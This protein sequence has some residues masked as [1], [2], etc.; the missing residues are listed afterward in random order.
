MEQG[1]YETVKEWFAKNHGI[2]THGFIEWKQRTPAP[3]P[4]IRGYYYWN[5]G[6]GTVGPIGKNASAAF[7]GWSDVDHAISDF[8]DTSVL[9]GTKY[10]TVGGG[11][12][13]GQITAEALKKYAISGQK[14]KNAGYEAV[15][16]DIEEIKGSH[17]MMIPLFAQAF[18]AIKKAGLGVGVTVSKCAPYQADT[19]ID[20]VEFIKAWVKDENIDFMS[21]QLYTTGYEPEPLFI[22]TS[23]CKEAGCTWDLWRNAVPKVVP[24]IVGQEQYETVKEWFAKNYDIETAGFFEW[25]QRAPAAEVKLTSSANRRKISS[26]TQ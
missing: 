4:E 13:S 6:S 10:L 2:E 5:W 18:A 25:K 24:S 15:M 22:E 14:I 16:F 17:T 23:F 3:T 7:T 11:D 1:Q 21:P 8:P 26:F 12:M 19:P 9:L 20:S